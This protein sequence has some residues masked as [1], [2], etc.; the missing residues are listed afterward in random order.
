RVIL[1][2][3]RGTAGA[4]ERATAQRLKAQFGSARM[5][6]MQSPFAIFVQQVLEI[7]AEIIAAHFQ[8]ETLKRKSLIEFSPEAPL[9]DQ[10]VQRLK[11][12]RMSLYTLNVDPDQMAEVDQEAEQAKR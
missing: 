1:V 9:A 2:L 7:K 6:P 10:A 12:K 8:A 3:R 11:D 5:Q 4:S